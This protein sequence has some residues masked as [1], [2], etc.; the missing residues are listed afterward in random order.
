MPNYNNGKIYKLVSNVT[1]DIYIGST[2]L[3]LSERLSGHKSNFKCYLEGTRA[4]TV[5]SFKIL[6]TGDYNICLIEDYPC[7]SLEE[8]R[9]RERFHIEKN[10]CV[11]EL[12]PNRSQKEWIE[13]NKERVKQFKQKYKDTHKEQIIEKNKESTICDVCGSE[14]RKHNLKRHYKSKKCISINKN[15]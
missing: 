3:S 2:C 1:D 8:L 13:T 5:S 12:I 11:N 15:V 10:I 7:N 9:Q 6:Q 4:H 14:V